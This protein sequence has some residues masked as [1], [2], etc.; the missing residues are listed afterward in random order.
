MQI[1]RGSDPE[2]WPVRFD[3][4]QQGR[5]EGGRQCAGLRVNPCRT[6]LVQLAQ[7]QAAA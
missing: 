3:A 7:R 1:L 5:D 4:S 2:H 6:D